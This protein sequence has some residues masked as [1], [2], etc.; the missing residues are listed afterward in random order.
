MLMA[1][2]RIPQNLLIDLAK[3][4]REPLIDLLIRLGDRPKRGGRDRE[5]EFGHQHY[6]KEDEGFGVDMNP[7]LHHGTTKSEY[8]Q[9]G[10][11][12]PFKDHWADDYPFVLS[13]EAREAHW[14]VDNLIDNFED[15]SA[16]A[17]I[18]QADTGDYG[19]YNPKSENPEEQHES[20]VQVL[21][22]KQVV[23]TYTNPTLDDHFLNTL[24]HEA[25]LHG[26]GGSHYEGIGS[27]FEGYQPEYERLSSE[28]IEAIRGTEASK[29]M[30]NQ[31]IDMGANYPRPRQEGIKDFQDELDYKYL[32]D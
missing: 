12:G 28:L 6:H 22:S 1:R 18:Q 19:F 14:A 23:P 29:A 30:R 16:V 27:T 7:Y 31:L 9:Q 2:Q 25:F 20:T 21:P 5:T 32:M 15:E 4:S 24:I 3:T 26:V 8:A 10:G 13:P 17:Y 11:V